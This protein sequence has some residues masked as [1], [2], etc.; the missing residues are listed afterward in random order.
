MIT[1]EETSKAK[2]CEKDDFIYNRFDEIY[3]CNNDFLLCHF[4][5]GAEYIIPYH[6]EN[7]E[8]QF[9]LWLSDAPEECVIA[10]AKYVFRN[11]R[12][13]RR[14]DYRF[15]LHPLSFHGEKPEQRN[16]WSV[17]IPE[18]EMELEE[19]L[20][21]KKRYNIKREKR[22][23]SEQIGAFKVKEYSAESVPDELIESYFRFKL[24]TYGIDYHLSAREYLNNFH[25]SHVYALAFSE[26]GEIGA[27]ICSCEQGCNV[28]LENL[29]YN[30]E[31][32]K[33]SLGA[34]LYD[35]YLR[36][37]VKKKKR[38]LYLGYGHQ[39]YKSLYGS[40]EDLTWNGSIYRSAFLC[41]IT[42]TIPGLQRK[43]LH[44]VKRI[45]VKVDILNLR[46]I[47]H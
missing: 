21:S 46:K 10:A 16:H 37:L 3:T 13:I 24:S 44:S 15:Y 12:Q 23:A 29:T 34:I 25:V 38:R 32:K 41:L 45:L 14:I 8:A 31:Y 7:E 40:R 6:F 20:S 2:L 42:V 4:D 39:V 22:I 26:T 33:Y 11:Y 18:T 27:I 1:I 5:D 47:V 17:S 9:G 28:Y 35:E 19:R 30:P 36:I 43:I